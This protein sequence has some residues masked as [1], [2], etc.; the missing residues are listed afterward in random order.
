[1]LAHGM[2]SPGLLLSTMV[3]IPKHKG[4]N[5]SESPNYKAISLSSQLCKLFGL[6]FIDKH[7]DSLISDDLQFGY[8]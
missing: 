4:G 6:L 2:P 7:E 8:K 3:P 5:P 1:M